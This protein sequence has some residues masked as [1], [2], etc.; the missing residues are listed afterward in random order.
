MNT[1]GIVPLD[2]RVLVKPDPV[3]EVTKGGIILAASHVEKEK[4][5]TCKATLIA[6][7]VNAWAEA[8]RSPDFIA[9]EPGDRVLIAKYGGVNLKGYDGDDYRILNDEDLTGLLR[10]TSN[11]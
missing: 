2:M 11:V 3:E 8:R 10:E 9:P 6:V 7:G 1:S 5:A 4:Y